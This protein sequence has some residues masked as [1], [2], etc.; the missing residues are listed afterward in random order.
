MKNIVHPIPQP[1]LITG[2]TGMVGSALVRRLVKEGKE[3]HV[4]VLPY[5]NI[6]ISWEGKVHIHWGDIAEY[7]YVQRA[8][9]NMRTVFHLAAHVSDWGNRS[10]FQRVNVDGTNHVLELAAQ[11]H[12]R[13]ILTT[14][15][16]VYGK[17]LQRYVC[18]EGRPHGEPTGYYSQ[19]LQAQ[20]RIAQRLIQEKSLNCT[21]IRLGGVYGP[22]SKA[23][24]HGLIESIR[25]GPTLLGNGDQN[26]GLI[27]LDNAVEMLMTTASNPLAIG[28][29]YNAVDEEYISWKTYQSDLAKAANI[30]PPRSFP[31]SIARS[32]ASIQEWTWKRLRIQERPHFTQE[33]I[34]RII[35]NHQIPID[36]AKKELGYKPIRSYEEGI[37]ELRDY[38]KMTH[39]KK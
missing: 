34:N 26:A 12:Q 37:K 5:D 2:A 1:I 16:T 23:W 29:I 9:E 13:V 38:L 20:E 30:P 19:S 28:Q 11:N 27:H 17:D 31:A 32:L 39:L 15:S 7:R 21:I 25:L 14:G 24:V 22:T 4:F 36:K 35:S 18:T 8:M 33:A 6:P 10:Q 3:V